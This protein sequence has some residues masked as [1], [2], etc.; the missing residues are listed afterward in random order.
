MGKLFDY[1]DEFINQSDWKDLALIKFCLCAMGM[2]WGLALPEK[3]RK[4]AA[5][6]A[7]GIFVCTYMPLM[8]KM[9]RIMGIIKPRETEK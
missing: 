1:A 5:F 3:V 4:P 6:I 9:F 8:L 2:M 7:V